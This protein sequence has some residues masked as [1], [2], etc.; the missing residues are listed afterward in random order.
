MRFFPQVRVGGGVLRRLLAWLRGDPEEPGL[1]GGDHD[2]TDGNGR[3][4]EGT[5]WDVM[6]DW[7][8]GDGGRLQGSDLARDEQERALEGVAEQAERLSEADER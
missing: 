1:D 5:V 2:G 6:P 7:A 4:G 8:Y 3:D